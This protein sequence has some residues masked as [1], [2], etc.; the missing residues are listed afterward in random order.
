MMPI[1]RQP[2]PQPNPSAASLAP[3]QQ[4]SPPPHGDNYRKKIL[5]MGLSRSGK[6][7]IHKVVFEHVP[8]NK[9]FFLEPT[10]RLVKRDVDTSLV[11]FQLWECPEGYN[12]EKEGLSL[13]EFSTLLFVMDIQDNYHYPI[14]ELV[15][16]IEMA[17]QENS[18]I[19]IEIFVH[20]AEAL[21]G[22]YKNENFRQIQ[23]R[24]VDEL[25][26]ISG[27]F[28]DFP[29]NFYLTSVF[30]QSIFDALS[31]VVMRLVDQ[32]P[33]V[34]NLLELLCTNSGIQ[35][36]F[37][38]D[39]RTL[40]Y[41]ATNNSLVDSETHEL[42]C[43]YVKLLM[44]FS[45]LYKNLKYEPTPNDPAPPSKPPQSPSGASRTVSF[46]SVTFSPLSPILPPSH[47]LPSA[48]NTGTSSGPSSTAGSSSDGAGKWWASSSAP[49]TRHS[50]LAYWQ[51]DEHV[52]LV[53]LARSSTY[54]QS[55][56]LIEYNVTIFRQGLQQVIARELERRVPEKPP[57]TPMPSRVHSGAT[58]VRVGAGTGAGKASKLR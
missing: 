42:C 4:Q 25:L 16:L 47:G 24:L 6:T 39:M 46:D 41:I 43:D 54:E 44:Q 57:A 52:C 51:M 8:P 32:L 10:T 29:L 48:D 49:L 58:E 38:F 7:S 9:S 45:D 37:L 33:T 2:L 12:L 34:E 3:S 21:S 27:D 56:S 31:R 14:L 50:T 35:K 40:L 26:D 53:A 20:K 18:K 55:R 28:E 5:V 11:A 19:N 23:Q 30:D 15:K 1:A 17:Y 22:E 13:A 36:A